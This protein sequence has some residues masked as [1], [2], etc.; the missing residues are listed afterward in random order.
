MADQRPN[1]NT[2]KRG[3]GNGNGDGRF[4][5]AAEENK[6]LPNL[7]EDAIGHASGLMREEVR[8]ARTEVMDGVR[9][10]QGG[11]ISVG[12]AVAILLPAI[13]LLLYAAAFGMAAAGW[14]PAWAG[15]AIVGVIA[16][17]I[18]AILLMTGKSKMD[19]KKLSAPKATAEA[20]RT[21]RFAKEQAR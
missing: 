21:A 4:T 10:M 15:A 17:V 14:V 3:N 13:T 5:S 8:L 16:A 9:S 2:D 11:A 6:S 7:V 20:G 18:G 1:E 12:I 19:P